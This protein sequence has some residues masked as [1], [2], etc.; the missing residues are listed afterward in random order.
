MVYEKG[1]VAKVSAVLGDEESP[2]FKK[3]VADVVLLP[4]S[5]RPVPIADLSSSFQT[6]MTT[7]TG[8]S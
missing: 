8:R 2:E 4:P 5:H 7:N 1:S 6:R 3:L